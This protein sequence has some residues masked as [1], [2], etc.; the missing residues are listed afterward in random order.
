MWTNYSVVGILRT[1]SKFRKRKKISLRLR[2][3]ASSIKREQG[4]FMSQSCS[5]CKVMYK[6]V[7]CKCENV[8]TFGGA[9]RSG[10]DCRECKYFP[11]KLTKISRMI[12]K[13]VREGI[14]WVSPSYRVHFWK[15]PLS[16][17]SAWLVELWWFS[18][19]THPDW[20]M[21]LKFL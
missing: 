10:S 21:D 6:K 20:Q 17:E 11:T 4:I 7:C 3:F 18:C 16:D 19:E 12:R 2:F 13:A 8:F 5:D 14:N 9:K 15:S 1:K